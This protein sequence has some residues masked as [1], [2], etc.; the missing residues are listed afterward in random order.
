MAAIEQR[1]RILIRSSCF[2]VTDIDIQM[3][4]NGNFNLKSNLEKKTKIKLSV[5]DEKAGRWSSAWCCEWTAQKLTDCLE[6]WSIKYCETDPMMKDTDVEELLHR[7]ISIFLLFVRYNFTGPFDQLTEMQKGIENS[8][9]MQE[10]DDPFD[11]LK[12]NGE[13]VNVNMNLGKLL[14]F[15]RDN[16]RHLLNRSRNSMVCE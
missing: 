13:E 14:I 9:T 6:K 3:N 11:A 1:K 2:I 16:I 10:L 4:L 8:Q 15:V 5:S 7:T 12:V